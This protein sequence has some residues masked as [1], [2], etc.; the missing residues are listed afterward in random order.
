M[1]NMDQWSFEMFKPPS[2]MTTQYTL[3]R[4][5]TRSN[6]ML[7]QSRTG[8]ISPRDDETDLKIAELK[9]LARNR[10]FKANGTSS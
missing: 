10:F 5:N 7:Y 2:N 6:V 9:E 8:P 4:P 1:A 3:F